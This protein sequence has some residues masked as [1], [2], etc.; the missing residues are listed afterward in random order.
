M[1]DLS[2][3]IIKHLNHPIVLVGMMGVG[4]SH[5]GSLLAKELGLEF[6]DSDQKIEDAAGYD[7]ERIF[8]LD[9]EVKFRKLEA[10]IVAEL[11]NGHA[12]V[13]ATGGGAVM[14]DENRALIKDKTT[15]I[16]LDD[17]VDVLVERIGDSSKRP[18]LACG[19]A[20]ETLKNLLDER[21]PYYAQAD[22]TVKGDGENVHEKV[23]K[24]IEALHDFLRG[25]NQ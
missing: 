8:E 6:V 17:D 19:N 1:N 11:C 18:L 10:K 3:E 22:I 9:G 7:I 2:A 24:I 13:I 23:R 15:S 4:K 21:S 12:R 16:W 20:K 5:V 14:N 25:Q